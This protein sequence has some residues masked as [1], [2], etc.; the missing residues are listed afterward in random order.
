MKID[1]SDNKPIFLQ[2]AEGIEDAILSTAF[3]EGE[4]VP[5][6]T[7]I[8]VRFGINPATALKGINLLVNEGLLYKKRGLGTFVADGAAKKILKKRAGAFQAEFIAPLF[9]EA[10]RLG[11]KK[12][13]LQQLLSEELQHYVCDE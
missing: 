13:N 5:S 3:A 8:S 11:L 2:V 10:K 9:Q 12:E 7:E 4:Q 6:T 1:V